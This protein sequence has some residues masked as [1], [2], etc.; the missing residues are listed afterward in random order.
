VAL[1]RHP[2]GFFI[3]AYHAYGP[4]FR[5]DAPMTRRA[6]VVAGALADELLRRDLD[7]GSERGREG[8]FRPFSAEVGVDVFEIEGAEH[9]GVRELLRQPYARSLVVQFAPEID[10]VVADAVDAWF[11]G[12]KIDLFA[13]TAR[14]SLFAAMTVVTPMS[15]RSAAKDIRSAGAAVMYAAFRLRPGLTL[16]SRAYRRARLGMQVAIDEAIGRHRRGD[17]AGAEK[18]SMIDACIAATNQAGERMNLRAIRGACF[19]ALAGTEIYIGRLLG[20]LLFELLRDR[21]ALRR[22]LAELDAVAPDAPIGEVLREA[23][24][25]RAAYTEALRCYPLIPAYPYTAVVDQE[26]GGYRVPAGQLLLFAPHV[27]HFVDEHYANPMAFDAE[28]HLPPRRESADSRLFASFGAGPH[29]CS[30]QGFVE[31]LSLA[32]VV[33]LLRQVELD[34]VRPAYAM[35]LRMKPLIA[36]RSPIEVRVRGKRPRGASM[37]ARVADERPRGEG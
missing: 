17:F 29:A 37:T 35:E 24:F 20:F 21:S 11:V 28:R 31:T 10:E 27:A 9:R 23:P 7:D 30:A 8:L 16:R 1:T 32:L 19:Y 3:D 14:L 18:T 15:L 12:E 36:P 13:T 22:V 2:L 4:V 33:A 26:I 34:L 5:M 6:V 25:L